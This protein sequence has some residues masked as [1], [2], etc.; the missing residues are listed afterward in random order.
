MCD[1]FIMNLRFLP[2]CSNAMLNVCHTKR[3]MISLFVWSWAT[4]SE[5]N[6]CI[7][8]SFP[9]LKTKHCI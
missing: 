8:F 2:F 6:L 7:D 1:H 4:L 5:D 9:V 3:Q